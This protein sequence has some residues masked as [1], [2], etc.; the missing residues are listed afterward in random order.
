VNVK[1]PIR[2]GILSDMDVPGISIVIPTLNC[3]SDLETAL[4]SIR[5]Q[6]YPAERVEIIVA[7][8]GSKDGTRKVASAWNCII[9]END[10]VTAEAGKAT[11][12]ARAT[13][14]IVG[15]VDS[16]NEMTSP[17]FLRAVAEA[18]TDPIIEGAEPIQFATSTGMSAINRYFALLGMN[19]PLI[20][21][22]GTY[23]RISLVTG[24]WTAVRHTVYEES[25]SLIKIRFDRS[26][27]PTVGA[28][29]FFTRRAIAVAAV[30]N[31]F[32]FD[33]DIL[34]NVR[35]DPSVHVAK[36]KLGIAHHYTSSLRHFARKQRRRAEDF[37]HF[38]AVGL[39]AGSPPWRGIVMFAISTITIVP[40]LIQATIGWLRCRDRAW[41]YHVPACWITLISY[42]TVVIR[43]TVGRTGP[44]SR[45]GWGSEGQ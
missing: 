2:L 40:L 43:H 38:S 20:L 12:L 8:G 4:R 17:T 1:G 34:Q 45:I 14:E 35:P 18:L 15:F 25:E 37:L 24:K 41:L 30:R 26:N 32:L 27:L 19:D 21:F 39:R 3:A 5:A 10:L 22:L 16:D 23:D 6:H 7:D 31:S 42:G 13:H 9:V 29:G 33:V 11:G 44:H 36:L 28:N